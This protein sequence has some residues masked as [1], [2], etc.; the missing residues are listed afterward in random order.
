MVVFVARAT[1]RECRFA[2]RPGFLVFTAR[3]FPR[4]FCIRCRRA[5]GAASRSVGQS[6]IPSPAS[7]IAFWRRIA[8]P[9]ASSGTRSNGSSSGCETS[10]ALRAARRPLALSQTDASH[11]YNYACKASID[12]YYWY[13]DNIRS[14]NYGS[15][16]NMFVL[17]T[18]N[19]I[20]VDNTC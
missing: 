5:I 12:A 4:C 15:H 6:S 20:R 2:R 14:N 7:L 9:H 3:R 1:S 11:I 10:M 18:T 8:R 17:C 13:F 19:P 16:V